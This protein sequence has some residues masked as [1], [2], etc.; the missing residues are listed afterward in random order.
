[1]Q[2]VWRE[3]DLSLSRTDPLDFNLDVEQ[4]YWAPFVGNAVSFDEFDRASL[5]LGHSEY[6]PEPCISAGNAFPSMPNS[7]LK[8]K[9]AENYAHN[10]DTSATLERQ[11][12]MHP[13]YVDRVLSISAKDAILEPNNINR[14]LPLPKFEDAS[15]SAGL[16]NPLFIYRDEQEIVQGGQCG[17]SPT[18]LSPYPYL[19][20]PFLGGLGRKVTGPP[21][22]LTFT[23]GGWYNATNIRLSAGQS[24]R[25]TGG[26]VGTIALPLLADFWTYPDSPE[27]PKSDPFVASGVNGWQISLPVT[28]AARPDFRAFSAGRGGAQS[29]AIDPSHANWK[30]ASG[31]FT[32]N[33][34][35]T[36]GSDN[37]IYWITRRHAPRGLTVGSPTGS[38]L[39]W[40]PKIQGKARVAA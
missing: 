6:R 24:D 38:A 33:G 20:S 10:L 26:M 21:T 23:D 1:M 12:A 27:L 5:F 18:S 28:S 11:P 4:M 14:Y 34:S 19:L 29:V 9:F 37:S 7:G 17:V 30:I 13:A 25:F 15:L 8:V 16:K 39:L 35:G 2:T 22:S 40:T 32:P 31:G 36:P 3:I